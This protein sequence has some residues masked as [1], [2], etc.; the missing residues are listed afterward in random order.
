MSPVLRHIQG[1][2]FSSMSSILSSHFCTT[3][4]PNT[5]NRRIAPSFRSGSN[6]NKIVGF[7]SPWFAF[8]CHFC[9]FCCCCQSVNHFSFPNHF[10][11]GR[12]YIS[13]CPGSPLK[14]QQK[15]TN[16][17]NKTLALFPLYIPVPTPSCANPA[18]TQTVTKSEFEQGRWS[19]YSLIFFPPP[20]S[21]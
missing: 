7:F 15:Q 1:R 5:R 3:M 4:F 18:L 16:K 14:K 13:T 21:V 19:C 12:A 20:L 11:E 8:H 17:K 9:C 10:F 2:P 6:C